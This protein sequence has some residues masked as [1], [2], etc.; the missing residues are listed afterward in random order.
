MN[1]SSDQFLTRSA[2]AGNKYGR[3]D[4]SDGLDHLEDR[5]HFGRRADDVLYAAALALCTLKGAILIK[6]RLAFQRFA[7][8][9]L[10]FF[11]VERLLNKIVGSEL[12][13]LAGRFNR[14]EGGHQHHADIRQRLADRTQQLDAVHIRHLHI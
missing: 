5:I 7:H 1:S 13:C 11:D 8:D 2:L 14:G 3:L 12:K 6:K 10:K 9:E 4:L